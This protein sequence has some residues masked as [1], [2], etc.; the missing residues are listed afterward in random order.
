MPIDCTCVRCGKQFARQP[1]KPAKYCSSECRCPERDVL[2]G[3]DNTL[4]IPLTRGQFATIDTADAERITPFRWHLN[5]GYA[6]RWR[7]KDDPPGANYVFMHRVV[8]DAPEAF[9][10]DHINRNTLDNRRS[11]LRLAS[12]VENAHNAGAHRDGTS[13]Y[14]GVHWYPTRNKWV[15]MI[16]VRGKRRHLGYFPTAEQAARAY[17]IAAHAGYG[18]FAPREISDSGSSIQRNAPSNH[19]TSKTTRMIASGENPA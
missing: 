6:R 18:E 13:K 1:S 9:L 12:H 10:V 15:A 7:C 5:R 17:E 19:A 14:R 16:Q 2:T 3:S 4:L 11:N 8:I